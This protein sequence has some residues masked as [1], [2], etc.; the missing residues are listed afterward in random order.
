MSIITL[1]L[2]IKS[3]ILKVKTLEGRASGNIDNEVNDRNGI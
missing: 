2:G 3:S 1:T